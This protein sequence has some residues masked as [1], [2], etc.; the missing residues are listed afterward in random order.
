MTALPGIPDDVGRM[1]AAVREPRR[2]AILIALEREPR[3]AMEIA[4]ELELNYS[5]VEWAMAQLRDAGLIVL[6]PKTVAPSQDHDDD[7]RTSEVAPAKGRGSDLRKVYETRHTG[8]T[9]MV[10]AL[11]AIAGT[12]RPQS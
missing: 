5:T 1:L 3:S 7:G 12:A 9:T 6:R 4:T 8:W 10:G 11:A 2:L